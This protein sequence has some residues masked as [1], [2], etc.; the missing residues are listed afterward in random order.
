MPYPVENSTMKSNSMRHQVPRTFAHAG[1]FIRE[2]RVGVT[3]KIKPSQASSDIGSR[4]QDDG[5][6]K[7]PLLEA[8]DTSRASPQCHPAGG[9]HID[10]EGTTHEKQQLQY[11][12][13]GEI[14]R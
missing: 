7:G 11:K 8:T 10:R 6:D 9:K 12:K 14:A 2:W 13:Q 4:G 5:N 3:I 1:G